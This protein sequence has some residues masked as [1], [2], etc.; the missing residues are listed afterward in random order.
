MHDLCCFTV[1]RTLTNAFCPNPN[2]IHYLS[3][4][5]A[6]IALSSC[7]VSVLPFRVPNGSYSRQ[8]LAIF[9]QNHVVPYS[10]RIAKE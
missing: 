10:F 3:Y 1:I 6:F 2:L 9:D 8:S 7:S 4:W 5:L